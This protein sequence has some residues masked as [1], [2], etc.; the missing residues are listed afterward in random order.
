MPKRDKTR[1]FKKRYKIANHDDLKDGSH[2]VQC[3]DERENYYKVILP[4]GEE[5]RKEILNEDRVVVRENL[6]DVS[7]L[8]TDLSDVGKIDL[9]WGNVAKIHLSEFKVESDK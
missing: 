8:D 1:K 9:K 3:K 5:Q 6:I 7:L 4:E 2:T